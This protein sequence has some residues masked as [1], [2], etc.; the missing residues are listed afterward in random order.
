[1]NAQLVYWVGVRA[2]GDGAAGHLEDERN[3]AASYKEGRIR[4]GVPAAL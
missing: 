4:A 3:E 2:Q 1:M